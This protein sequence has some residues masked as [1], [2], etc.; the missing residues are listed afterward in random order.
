MVVFV[1]YHSHFVPLSAYHDP[2]GF[3]SDR[4]ENY[5][6][7]GEKIVGYLQYLESTNHGLESHIYPSING[8]DPVIIYLFYKGWATRAAIS[9]FELED[10]YGFNEAKWS[11]DRSLEKLLEEVNNLS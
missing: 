11:I 3:H 8:Y 9:S 4:S 2:Y 10:S 1:P 5:R 6:Y 7:N